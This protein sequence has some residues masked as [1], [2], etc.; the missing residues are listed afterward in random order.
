M[1][2]V[3]TVDMQQ[4]KNDFQHM[5]FNAAN[6]ERILLFEDFVKQW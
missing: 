6:N 5:L 3:Q 4:K 1:A 2:L